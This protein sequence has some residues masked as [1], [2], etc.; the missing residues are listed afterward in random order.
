MGITDS[1]EISAAA[2]MGRLRRLVSARQS[3]AA[4]AS[5]GSGPMVSISGISSGSGSGSGG[6]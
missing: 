3:A 1:R 2:R 6:A 5:S 4:S